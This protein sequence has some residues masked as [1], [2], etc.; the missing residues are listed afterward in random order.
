MIN[1]NQLNKNF[2]HYSCT[3][4][5]VCREIYPKNFF[6]ENN[7][8]V[9]K[10]NLSSIQ[11]KKFNKFCPGLGFSYINNKKKDSNL[12]GKFTASYVGFS[13]NNIL[14]KN[15]ASGG[16]I[17]EILIYLIQTKK[18]DYVLMPVQS[19]NYNNL[20]EYKLTKNINEIKKNSQ[21]I[22]TKIPVKNLLLKK[23][24]KIV[25]VGLPD[26]ISS[27]KK[28]I[29][30][31]LI[32]NN[33]K[34]FIGPMVGINM[35]SNSIDGIKLSFNI[36]SSAKI[37]KLKWREGKWPGYL[38]IKFN[39]YKKIKLKKFYYNF[40][41]PFYCSHES[42]LSADFSNEDADISVGDAWS[43]KYENSN[44]GGFSLIWSKNKIGDNLLN[45]MAKEKRISLEKINYQDAI[46]MHAHMLDFKKRGSQYRRNI[47]KLF[48]IP[49]PDHKLKKVNFNL[50]RY[51]IEAIILTIIMILRS[52]AGKFLLIIFPPNFLGLIF[53][54]LRY[55]WKN[56]TKKTKR[57]KLDEY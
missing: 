1:N 5:G 14:R 49:V 27:V 53:Q 18:V 17:T 31:K 25:F 41:L 40:L 8:F 21:S 39:G 2:F 23:S 16:V 50:S 56:L 11:L 19:E 45:T 42:L 43:P 6:I 13:N 48:N 4:C 7:N 35:D 37:E 3:R 54:K 24:K 46:K 36:K 33:I 34:F 51:F 38:G 29:K 12:I 32:K 55:F 10:E 30:N 22:Y 20:P 9:L 52:R 26:Q 15:S 47:Y 28:L 57:D 44:Q